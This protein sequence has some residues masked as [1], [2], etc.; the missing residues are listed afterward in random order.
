MVMRIWDIS[1]EPERGA[2]TNKIKA[3][4]LIL[5]VFKFI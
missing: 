3:Y 1:S 4:A 5:F 2:N